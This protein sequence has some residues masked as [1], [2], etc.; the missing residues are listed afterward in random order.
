MKPEL[1][2][3]PL[4]KALTNPAWSLKPRLIAARCGKSKP[5]PGTPLTTPKFGSWGVAV[6]ICGGKNTFPHCSNPP[7]N[8]GANSPGPTNP[9]PAPRCLTK[10]GRTLEGFAPMGP[11]IGGCVRTGKLRMGAAEPRTGAAKLR[12]GAEKPRPCPEAD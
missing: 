12:T 1:L 10:L 3:K 8:P 6:I 7:Q 5:R 11:R 9:R 4:P 2:K